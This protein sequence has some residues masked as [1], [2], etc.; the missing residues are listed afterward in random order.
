MK[1]MNSDESYSRMCERDDLVHRFHVM[2]L[3]DDEEDEENVVTCF[4]SFYRIFLLLVP[5]MLLYEKSKR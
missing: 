4:D 1:A 3:A 5:V 2:V